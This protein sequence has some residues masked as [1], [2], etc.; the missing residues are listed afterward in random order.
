MSKSEIY[1]R[2]DN[3]VNA[4]VAL[5]H[6]SYGEMCNKYDAL[7]QEAREDNVGDPQDLASAQFFANYGYH[8]ED[9]FEVYVAQFLQEGRDPVMPDG[10]PISVTAVGRQ[11][12][13]GLLD[14]LT[15]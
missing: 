3:L 1:D 7:E 10:T 4:L 11:R 13:A 6:T 12:M 14:A 2:Y 8:L 5:G 15:A 9:A